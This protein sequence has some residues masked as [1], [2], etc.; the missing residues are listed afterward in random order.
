MWTG[1]RNQTVCYHCPKAGIEY[2]SLPAS[3]VGLLMTVT[4]AQ[5]HSIPMWQETSLSA[6]PRVETVAAPVRSH[7]NIRMKLSPLEKWISTTAL[8]FLVKISPLRMKPAI[9]PLVQSGKL[10]NLV[11]YVTHT[12]N[13][14]N[15]AQLKK[16]HIVNLMHAIEAVYQLSLCV[17][18]CV[19][20]NYQLLYKAM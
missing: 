8:L 19:Y 17:Q 16:I 3:L 12:H 13:K 9:L 20:I 1:L 6:V 18:S 4:A 11:K 7:V 5:S 15:G 10:E 2:A 14:A